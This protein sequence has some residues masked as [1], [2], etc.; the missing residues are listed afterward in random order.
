MDTQS[1]SRQSR[2]A[3]AKTASLWETVREK[4]LPLGLIALTVV[5]SASVPL[6]TSTQREAAEYR[7][8]NLQWEIMSLQEEKA[9]LLQQVSELLALENLREKAAKAGLQ[10]ASRMDD[11]APT[12]ATAP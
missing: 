11:V 2:K 3:Q 6:A 10:P 9:Q 12:P 4:V 8:S 5:L 1:T 7:I